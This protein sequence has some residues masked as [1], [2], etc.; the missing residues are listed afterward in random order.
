MVRR[1]DF[2]FNFQFSFQYGI[3]PIPLFL[4]FSSIFISLVWHTAKKTLQKN[5]MLHKSVMSQKNVTQ[6]YV[7][8]IQ[9]VPGGH[10]KSLEDFLV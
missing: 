10:G 5:V 7:T 4:F 3:S 1:F 6:C 2:N 8:A 9:L